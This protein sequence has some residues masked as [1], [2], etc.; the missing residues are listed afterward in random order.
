VSEGKTMPAFLMSNQNSS[1]SQAPLQFKD[2]MLQAF[3][4]TTAA[5]SISSGHNA[6][7]LIACPV[8]AKHTATQS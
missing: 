8:P 4:K 2:T 1:N 6:D 5:Q 3:S 7:E